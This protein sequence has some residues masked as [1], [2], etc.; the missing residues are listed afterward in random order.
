MI[1]FCK[2]R[3]GPSSFL[4]MEFLDQLSEREL[5]MNTLQH[6]VSYDTRQPVNSEIPLIS[7]PSSLSRDM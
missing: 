4:K 3:D 2:H 7:I 6:G 1:G 5:F